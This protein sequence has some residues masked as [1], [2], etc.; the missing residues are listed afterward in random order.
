[1]VVKCGF[2]VTEEMNTECL[3]EYM[4]EGD[5]FEYDIYLLQFGFYPVAVGPTL[6]HR[7]RTTIY[8]RRRNMQIIENKI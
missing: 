2:H 6:V 8:I 4:T 5:Y 1:M 3:E 7:R